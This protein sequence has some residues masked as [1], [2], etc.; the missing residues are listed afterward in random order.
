M[1]NEASK[2]RIKHLCN[3][4]ANESDRDRF[5]QLVTELNQVFDSAESSLAKH[6][7]QEPLSAVTKSS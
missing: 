2:Q 3:L 5:T 7:D 1:L 4:I 6:D